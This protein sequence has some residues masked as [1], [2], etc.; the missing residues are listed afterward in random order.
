MY[1]YLYLF[2]VFVSDRNFYLFDKF[3][4]C[5]KNNDS[6]LSK[7]KYILK[8]IVLVSNL[9]VTDIEDFEDLKHRNLFFPLLFLG[10]VDIEQSEQQRS[11]YRSTRTRR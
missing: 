3:L 9:K 8:E 7:K 10:G 11:R 4:V 1:L 5:L 2:V 6:I